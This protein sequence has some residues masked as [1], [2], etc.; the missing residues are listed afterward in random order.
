MAKNARPAPAWSGCR[1]N[2]LMTNQPEITMK[3]K[4]V[5]GYPNVLYG[6]STEGRRNRNLMT[7]Q[8]VA[9]KK[10]QSVKVTYVITFSN[11]PQNSISA[12]AHSDCVTT[13]YTGVLYSG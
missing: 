8:A 6:R 10:I 3:I 4:G 13:E 2:V 5:T 7:M 12:T 11:V 1:N 9:V